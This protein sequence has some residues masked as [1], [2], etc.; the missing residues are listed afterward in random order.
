MIKFFRKIRQNLLSEGKTGKTDLS[1]GNYLKYAIGEIVLVVIGILIALQINNWNENKKESKLE[2][3]ILTEIYSALESDIE[4]QTNG[5]IFYIERANKSII[6]LTKIK[7]NTS[8][9]RDSIR[10]H[11]TNL[12]EVGLFFRIKTGPF[13]TL[14][15]IGLDKVSNTILRNKITELYSGN[16]PT[17]AIWINDI[18]RPYIYEKNKLFEEIFTPKVIVKDDKFDLM[19]DLS[20]VESL[21]TSE[22][23]NLMLKKISDILPSTIGRLKFNVEKMKEVKNEIGKELNLK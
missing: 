19:I 21:L 7:E 22:K 4:N 12:R 3:I 9:P 10:Y 15:S 5:V 20:H 8:Y 14:N 16:L 2:T 1:S 6:E 23:F 17:L 18:I 13:E 11:L